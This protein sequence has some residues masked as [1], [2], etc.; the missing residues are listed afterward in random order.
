[1]DAHGVVPVHPVE[2]GEFDVVDGPPRSVAG[3]SDQFGLVER[4]DGL[5]QGVVI[6]LSG[7]SRLG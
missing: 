7:Q 5:G 1:M 4:V 6:G 3:T 2:G